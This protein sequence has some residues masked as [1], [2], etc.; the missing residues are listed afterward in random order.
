MEESN[1][2]E[3]Q[4]L[5]SNAAD[6]QAELAFRPT[7]A[8]I[9]D[10]TS[11]VGS[12]RSDLLSKEEQIERLRAAIDRERRGSDKCVET[13]RSLEDL[14]PPDESAPVDETLDA[15]KISADIDEI[16]RLD[17]DEEDDE[18]DSAATEINRDEC[19]ETVETTE[20]DADVGT[21]SEYVR[22]DDEQRLQVTMQNGTLHALEEELVRAKERWAEGCAE[23]ARLAAQLAALQHKPLRL[24]IG[25]FLAMALP[26]LL[27][28]VYYALQ[29]YIS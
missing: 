19:S 14:R 12:L 6:M 20:V 3:I 9:D 22:L 26:V 21:V 5:A 28:C 2:A 10:L 7:R 15:K 8:D 23:R 17:Y 18:S 11:L 4:R 13:S 24:D 27:A 25:H 29:H 1:L 16:F